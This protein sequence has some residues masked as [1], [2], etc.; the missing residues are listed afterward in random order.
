MERHI[1]TYQGINTDTGYD[2]IPPNFYLDAVDIRIS[3]TEGASMGSWT[4]MKGNTEFFTIPVNNTQAFPTGS[5]FGTWTAT[6]PEIIGYTT[7]RNRVIL[8]VADSSG[9][10]GWIYDIQYD[11]ATREILPGFPALKY[12]SAT[13]NFSKNYPIEALGRYESGCVQR[14]YWTDYNNYLRSINIENPDLPNL[15]VDL[16]D[17]FPSVEYK[18][19]LLK[20]IF[21]GAALLAGLYQVAYRLRTSDGKETLISPPSNLIHLTNKSESLPQSAQYTGAPKGTMTNKAINVI[22]DTSDYADFSEID[23]FLVFHEDYAGTP[24]INYIETKTIA[25]NTI[26]FLIT[27][28]EAS[29][30]IDFLEYA[31]KAYPFKTCKTLTQKDSSLVIANTKSGYFSAKDRINELGETFDFDIL[32]YRNVATVITTN[33]NKFNPEYNIDAYWLVDWLDNQQYKYKSNGTTLGGESANISFEFTLEPITIDGSNQD[34]FPNIANVPID[35]HNLNDLPAGTNYYNTTYPSNSSPFISGLLKSYKRGET[36]RFGIVFYNKKGEAS[37][38]EHLADIKFPDISE[39]TDIETIAGTGIKYYP[40]STGVST[41][42]TGYAMGIEFNLDFSTCPLFFAEFESYQIV[43]VERTDTDKR[44]L[45]TGTIKAFADI[46][47]GNTVPEDFDFN[48]PQGFGPGITTLHLYADTIAASG[49]N[50]IASLFKFLQTGIATGYGDVVGD[51]VAIHTPELSF[52][53]ENIAGIAAST[54]NACLLVT[55]AYVHPTGTNKP[56]IPLSGPETLCNNAEDYRATMRTVVP[57]DSRSTEYIKRLYPNALYV[58]MKDT[59]TYLDNIAGPI[60]V[61]LSDYY[62]RNYYATYDNIGGS[63]NGINDPQDGGGGPSDT[64]EVSRG[65]TGI[66]TKIGKLTQDPITQD[67]LLFPTSTFE[68][69]NTVYVKPAA[70]YDLLDCIPIVDIVLPKSEVYGGMTADAVASNIFIPASPVIDKTSVT[71]RVFGGDIFISIFPFQSSSIELDPIFYPGS[72]TATPNAFGTSRVR[73]AVLPIESSLNIELAYGASLKTGIKYT[74]A[75]S[76]SE[77]EV[78]RQETA[79]TFKG[80]GESFDMYINNTVYSRENKDVTFF[81]QP[82]GG[83]NCGINDLRA[84]LSDVK[85]NEETIDSWTKFGINNYYDIDD[86]GPINKIINWKDTVYFY[87]DK[88]VGMYAINRAAITT[89]TDGTPTQLGTGQGFGKHRYISKENGSI[90]QWGIQASDTGMYFFDAIHRKIFMLNS[91]QQQD[92]NTPLS[93]IKGIHAFLQK[94]PAAS[95]IRKEFGGDDPILKK[96]IAVGKD[97]INDEIYFTFLGTGNFLPLLTST[98]YYP[99]NIV[100]SPANQTYYVV[101]FEFTSSDDKYEILADLIKNSRT[102]VDSDYFMDT[103]IV[104]DELMQQF[105]TRLSTQ[106]PTIWINN[107]DI[108]LTPSPTAPNKIYSH[109]YGDWGNFYGSVEEASIT[110][111][112][113]PQADINKVLRTLEFNSIVRDN[114]AIVDRNA[115]ITAF[116]IKTETQDTG[117][118]LFS[119]GRI[120]RRFDK[121]R[122]KIP[123]DINS[124]NQQGRLRSSHFIVTLYFDNNINKELIMNRLMSYFDYQ[125]F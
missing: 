19:P 98:T 39:E 16:I 125:V 72:G 52:N 13:L 96:G 94:L 124:V 3:T 5:P 1:N 4:N 85:I 107:G 9:S 59:S 46:T 100:Y 56:T 115:T 29:F 31:A 63:S 123:R 7:I 104:Y 25:G 8:L 106:T 71:P 54:S 108:L 118:V 67:P 60:T 82:V 47:I 55:G 122:V 116:R 74:E 69:F 79:N 86:Y 73:S 102:V 26:E 50:K 89:T 43:R 92:Q 20:A 110:M 17:I 95:F 90:H 114:T 113:N 62:L 66:L 23:I 38:V 6:Q 83:G 112:L 51:F 65:A 24:T 48:N 49:G 21:A 18:Q 119:A 99:G 76:N 12:Y 121:W 53:F 15:P 11:P 35:F 61:G 40:T 57:A 117:K 14:V 37:F 75:V 36:Y 81:S 32:R 58:E 30:P 103:T 111:V 80:A 105:S 34:G 91:G 101:L 87:Q 93:E 44:R 68:C 41:T 77:F 45:S 28:T 33:N 78:L 10:K 109:N 97:T 84:Y 42:T 22:I 2:S 88:G 70:P 120:K 27:G 64:Y